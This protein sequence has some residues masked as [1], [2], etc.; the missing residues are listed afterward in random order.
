VEL[1]RLAPGAAADL[2]VTDYHP[3]TPLCAGNLAGF[4]LFG[5]GAQ[6]VRHVMIAGRWALRDRAARRCDERAIL[7]RARE[8]APALWRRMETLAPATPLP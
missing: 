5:L 6:W 2:I 8:S 4:L 1:G 7:A 3:P